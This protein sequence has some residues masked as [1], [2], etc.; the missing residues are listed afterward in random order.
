M[1]GMLV[2]GFQSVS[3]FA[4]HGLVVGADDDALIWGNSQQTASTA[5][6]IGLKAMRITRQWHPGEAKVPVDFQDTIYRLVG[7][8]SGLR[9]VVSLYGRPEDTPHTDQARPQ[10][11]NYIAAL[12]TRNP[13][14]TDNLNWNDPN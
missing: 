10:D 6:M 3:A 9:I 11:R 7:D 5:R 1:V 13:H 4:G 14:G 8:M 12:R 2:A